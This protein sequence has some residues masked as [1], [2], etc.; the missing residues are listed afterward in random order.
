M[1]TVGAGAAAERGLLPGLAAPPVAPA[2]A[3]EAVSV[4]GPPVTEWRT[5]SP[6]GRTRPSAAADQ[7]PGNA[8]IGGGGGRGAGGGGAAGWP[9]VSATRWRISGRRS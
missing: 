6:Y 7:N 9:M 4:R 3:D 2:R 5:A 8:G 1:A